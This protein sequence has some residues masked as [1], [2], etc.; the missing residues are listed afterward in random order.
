MR[1]RPAI[2]NTKIIRPVSPTIETNKLIMCL[3]AKTQAN[4]ALDLPSCLMLAVLL[5]IRQTTRVEP[6]YRIRIWL[7]MGQAMVKTLRQCHEPICHYNKIIG[8]SNRRRVN[9]IKRLLWVRAQL[10]SLKLVTQPIWTKL[11]MLGQVADSCHTISRRVLSNRNHKVGLSEMTNPSHSKQ[12]RKSD[13]D[14][15][16]SSRTITF[17]AIMLP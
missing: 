17:L 9:P 1:E 4:L 15:S 8:F 3:L 2:E 12:P 16:T 6:T 14:L 7:S 5:Q 10:L 11:E 13:K